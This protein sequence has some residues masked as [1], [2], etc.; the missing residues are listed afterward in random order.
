LTFEDGSTESFDVV[1]GADGYCS[2]VR[3]AVSP[4][5]APAYAGY[6]LW[7]G[8][9]AEGLLTDPAVA[10][11]F[12]D[13]LLTV[14]FSGGHAILYL[15]PGRD[16]E[17]GKGER[18]VNWAVYGAP[19]EGMDF[20]E[21]TSLPPGKVP[22]PL[23]ARLVEVVDRHLPPAW[24][25][26]VHQTPAEALSVQPIYDHAVPTFVSGRVV[27][28][29]DAAALSRP[30]TAGGATKAMQEAVAFETAGRAHDFWPDLLAA[31]NADR[32]T[33]ARDLVETS[34]RVGRG[35]VEDTPDWTTMTAD[36]VEH[37]TNSLITASW[38]YRR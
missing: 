27:L 19:P 32:C 1:V 13:G 33:A 25:A 24:A 5:T 10:D 31:F 7:R 21:P 28:V 15:I 9:Y 20:T 4:D 37:F 36:E 2:T 14:C 17:T 22:A 8:N 11:L 16:G 29:G 6:V 30:H 34:R 3:R 23:A 38:L 18:W 12:D 35:L 26:V